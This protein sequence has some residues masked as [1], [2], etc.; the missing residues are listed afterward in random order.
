MNQ[1]QISNII[2]KNIIEKSLNNG[3]SLYSINKE[4]HKRIYAIFRIV[5]GEYKTLDRFLKIDITNKSSREKYAYFFIKHSNKRI[6]D[7]NWIFDKKDTLKRYNNI[8]LFGLLKLKEKLK[9]ES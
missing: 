3:D 7:M 1:E 9:S 2:D 4:L 8:Q 5:E 6:N